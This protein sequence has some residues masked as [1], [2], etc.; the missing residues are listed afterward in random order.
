VQNQ[1]L[2]TQHSALSQKLAE[3]EKTAEELAKKLKYYEEQIHN[4]TNALT[5]TGS[6]PNPNPN[7]KD[8]AKPTLR[9]V[10]DLADET[11]ARLPPTS[12]KP[13]AKKN[14]KD[15][16]KSAV[17]VQLSISAKAPN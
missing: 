5:R 4:A 3:S 6:N 12:V 8:D 7:S 17:T 11:L 1:D 13:T 2:K 16:K 9:H 10:L 15:V 14:G